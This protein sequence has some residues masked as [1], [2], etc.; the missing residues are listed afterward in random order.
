MD[1]NP[2]VKSFTS[3]LSDAPSGVKQQSNGADHCR[4]NCSRGEDI[5]QNDL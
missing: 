2:G 3:D 5:M 4:D 1:C